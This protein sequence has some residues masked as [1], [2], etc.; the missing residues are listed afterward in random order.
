VNLLEDKQFKQLIKTLRGIDG[1]LSVLISFQKSS[2]KPPALS[3]E[4]KA[5]L[6]L[7]NGKNSVKDMAKITNKTPHSIEI[8]LSRIRK[9]G[10]I[11]STTINKKTVYVKI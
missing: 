7:C 8:I 6:K 5:I 11:K 10:I 4:Q 9:K 2:R 1:K 3:K